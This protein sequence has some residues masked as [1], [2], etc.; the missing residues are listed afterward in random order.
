MKIYSSTGKKLAE[1]ELCYVDDCQHTDD[2]CLKRVGARASQS[3][4]ELC[5]VMN[6]ILIRCTPQA[7]I[8]SGKTQHSGNS[9]MF[10]ISIFS[11]LLLLWLWFCFCFFFNL[12]R[13]TTSPCT[14]LKLNKHI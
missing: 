10:L 7:S 2:E 12:V 5:R 11:C 3:Y 14:M 13:V 9:G 4:E 1:A 8:K 6:N